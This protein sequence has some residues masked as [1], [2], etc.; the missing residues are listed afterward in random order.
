M[1]RHNIE[2]L[3]WI[4]SDGGAVEW[5]RTGCV[6]VEVQDEDITDPVEAD[7]EA[8]ETAAILTAWSFERGR[9]VEGE[10]LLS[11]VRD[12]LRQT[13]QANHPLTAPMGRRA[14]RLVGRIDAHLSG[15][16]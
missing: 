1:L 12:F 15:G 7:D 10:L 14:D 9:V 6:A 11:E 4:A 3:G 13:A 2:D 16:R 8:D 5:H